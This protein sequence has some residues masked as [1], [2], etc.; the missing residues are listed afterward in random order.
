[1]NTQN[2][3]HDI[4]TCLEQHTFWNTYFPVA[5]TW[6]KSNLNS[7]LFLLSAWE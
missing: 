4:L 5:I 1:M 6:V 3:C 2:E 7:A